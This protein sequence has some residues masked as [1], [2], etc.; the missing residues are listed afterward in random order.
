MQEIFAVQVVP[1]TRY[2]DLFNDA[3]SGLPT[4]CAA[5]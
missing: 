4:A 2:P 3:G 5:E 1:N